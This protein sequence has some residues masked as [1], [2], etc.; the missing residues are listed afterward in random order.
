MSEGRD[1]VLV[2]SFSVLC[3]REGTIFKT[4]VEFCGMETSHGLSSCSL[5]NCDR[6][7]GTAL[8]IGY[9]TSKDECPLSNLVWVDQGAPTRQRPKS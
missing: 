4:P 5:N 7:L 1:F 6:G 8:R 2:P 3:L 9:R